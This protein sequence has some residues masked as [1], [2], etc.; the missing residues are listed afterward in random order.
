MKK[1]LYESMVMFRDF[2]RAPKE[3]LCARNEVAKILNISKRELDFQQKKYTLD[4]RQWK[5]Q[6]M[7]FAAMHPTNAITTAKSIRDDRLVLK[8]Q[9]EITSNEQEPVFV[10]IVKNDLKRI[11]KSYE[12]HK[13]MGVKNFVFVDNNSDD[14][15]FEWL[16]EQDATVFWTDCK[17]CSAA[18]SAWLGMVFEY[19]GYD[20]WYLILDSDE[21]LVYP[22]YEDNNITKLISLLEERKQKRLLSFMLDMYTKE[23]IVQMDKVSEWKFDDYKYFDSDSYKL[24][25]NLHYQK[26]IGGPRARV[27]RSDN[28]NGIEMIQNK[29]PLVYMT[30]GEIYRYHYVYPIYH[31]FDTE[32]VSVL[33]HYKFLPG[34][35]KK[36]EKIAEQGTYANGSQLYKDS[37]KAIQQNEHI[38]FWNSDSKEYTNS[39]S[40]LNIDIVK[41]IWLENKE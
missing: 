22:G 38:K 10:C 9:N 2:I 29:Y 39:D 5:K 11:Q 1:F 8:K 31:N 34:D 21:L 35:L 20:R 41:S 36:Y 23:E 32:C 30:R 27:I 3:T 7:K 26:V 18:K 13:K 37:L 33:L 28:E 40:L 14:G 12:H 15:T 19:V 4:C 16:I 24:S 6:L 17:F 25:R